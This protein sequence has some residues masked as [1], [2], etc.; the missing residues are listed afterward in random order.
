MT[1]TTPTRRPTPLPRSGE[2]FLTDGGLETTLVFHD[3]I[4]LPEFASIDLLRDEAG[5]E[6]LRRYYERYIAIA[7][8]HDTGFVLESATWR[9]G[10]EWGAV[11]GYDPSLLETLNRRAVTLLHALRGA[12]PATPMVVSGCLGPRG[13]GYDP[14][15]ATSAEEAEAYHGWQLDVLADAGVDAV[16]AITMTNVPE[17]VG[18]ARG[19]AA[20]NLPSVI[21]YTVE[22]DGRLPTGQT[23]DEA[24][25]ET[26]AATDGAPAY[27][28]INCAHPSHFEARLS[29]TGAWLERIRGLRVNASRCSHAEL[30]EAT[31]L[32][33]G[34]PA[35]LAAAHRR[36][37]ARLPHLAVLGGCCGTDHRHVAAIAAACWGSARNAA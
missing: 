6:R 25:A 7:L 15:T 36:L 24:I 13:D 5:A 26:D 19:A 22:T 8:R 3:G 21:S 4:D 11:I 20:R 27:Y 10:P 14:G 9:G 32:D 18:I 31:E 37:L 16:S 28:M 12:H 2:L 30:D 35:E 17:A 23:L 33:D 29:G 34:D 1:P